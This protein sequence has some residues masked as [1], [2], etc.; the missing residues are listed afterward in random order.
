MDNT[1]I[2][3]L[4]K[5]SIS[6]AL[7]YGLYVLL[8]RKDT[9]L[10]LKRFYFLFAIF[11]SLIFPSFSI[12]LS[13]NEEVPAQIPTY[14]LSEIS[15]GPS[16]EQQA[17]DVLFDT[18]PVVL[19]GLFLTS[20]FF[21]LRFGMQL[22][23][24]IR[25]KA[26]AESEE[27]AFGHIVKIKDKQIS[28]F[29]FFNWIFINSNNR[30]LGEIEEII[31]HEL[32]H[33]RQYHSVDVILVE[34]LCASLWWNPFVWLF[35]REIKIN[36]EYLADQGVLQSGY[37]TKEYQYILLKASNKNTGIPLIN[38]F[39][40]SQLKK[41]IA[42][43]NKRK[44]SMS[45][46]FKYL[47][48][49]PLGVLLLLGNAVQASTD[50]I[51]LAAMKYDNLSDIQQ[52]AQKKGQT[53]VTAETVPSFP[54]GE[55]AM[56]D[57]VADNLKYPA[58]AF[59]NNKAGKVIVRYIVKSTGDLSDVTVIR[60]VDPLLDAEAVRIVKAMPNWTPGK[61]GGKAVD[62]YYTLPIIFRIKGGGTS[63]V[64]KTNKVEVTN[65]VAADR[66]DEKK[67]F[68]AVDQMPAYPGG[69]AAM[70]KY[71]QTNLKYPKSAQNAGTQGRVTIRF[72]VQKTGEITDVTVIR[73]ISSELDAEAV[74]VVKAM[75]KWIPGKIK[76]QVVPVYFTLP[77][78]YKL[79]KEDKTVS[80]KK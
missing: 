37:D 6:L 48:C 49:V 32:V 21:I 23:S 25:L 71:V 27:L 1:I 14:W 66:I 34:L 24:I 67:P 46:S 60:G 29:S 39:N 2:T 62:V 79:K 47:L 12:E 30:D 15:V 80:A 53:Y 41:R 54:G 36:L 50:L 33:A 63:S 40:V 77:I 59:E 70:Q 18:W 65:L 31:A 10:R 26:R 51:D 42:M 73:G 19:I 55:K 3:Y 7:F 74:R 61:Q 68:V 4:L 38:N 43:M 28:P 5:T 56:Q 9:F 45:R 35:K 44:T 76:G 8:F 58:E 13:A 75:P 16:M 17:S 52:V 22:Y 69:E 20:L 57:F 64:G 78:V 11:F 72:V